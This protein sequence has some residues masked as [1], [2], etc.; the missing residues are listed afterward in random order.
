MAYDNN[1]IF[2]KILR[3]ELPCHKVYEDEKTL[4][5]MDIMPRSDG[6][7]L[8]ISKAPAVNI[9]DVDL[10]TLN[11]IM[12]TVHKLAPVVRDA[13]GCGGIMI[14]QFN[15]AAAGQMVFHIHFHI[16]PRWKDVPLRPHSGEM[17]DPEVL[18]ENARKIIAVLE[19]REKA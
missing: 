9:F 15:E 4:A 14:Q 19:E 10:E 13:M 16:V 17:E 12:A 11:D 3:G 7:T 5:F 18:A 1:N 6:H 8:V 2:A